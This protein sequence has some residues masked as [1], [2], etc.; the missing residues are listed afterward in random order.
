MN[1]SSLN[2][3]PLD[4]LSVTLKSDFIDLQ[5]TLSVAPFTDLQAEITVTTRPAIDLQAQISVLQSNSSD[6]LAELSIGPV[7]DVNAQIQVSNYKWASKSL[8]DAQN[9]LV[10][11]PY[12]KCFVVDDNIVPN[13]KIVNNVL[14]PMRYFKS[15]TAPDGS[16]L[17]TGND[18][19]D[20][21]GFWKITDASDS[22][23]WSASATAQVAPSTLNPIFADSEG[24][25]LIDINVSDWINGTYVIDI[26]FV[27]GNNPYYLYWYRSLDGGQ[28]WTQ[29]EEPIITLTP[30]TAYLSVASPQNQAKDGFIDGFVL[31]TDNNQLTYY[32]YLGSGS[33]MYNI[34]D[35][36]FN[37]QEWNLNGASVFYNKDKDGYF[38]VFSGYHSVFENSTN[39]GLYSFYLYPSKTSG[40]GPNYD[41]TTFPK[42]ILTSPSSSQQN[43]NSYNRP[44]LNFDGTYLWLNYQATIVTSY[45]QNTIAGST[46]QITTQNQNFLCKSEDFENFTY[47]T[48]IIFTDGTTLNGNTFRAWPYSF[49]YQNGYYYFAGTNNGSSEAYQNVWQYVQNDIIADVSNYILN[50][51]ISE[52]AGS[53]S[54]LSIDIG[55]Q[56]SQWY[57]PAPTQTGYQAIAKNN[58]IYLFQGYYNSSGVP[59]IAPRNVYYIDDITQNTTYNQ[60]S[61]TLTGRDFY[62]KLKVNSSQYT[63]N[64]NGPTFLVDPFNNSSLPNWSPVSGQWT[65]EP[66]GTGAVI[67]YLV[68][69]A[70][71]QSD[72]IIVLNGVSNI[73]PQQT[74]GVAF[75]VPDPTTTQAIYF[76]VSYQ[77]S[78]HWKRIKISGNGLPGSTTWN[79]Y[80]Q[81]NNG[82]LPET[83]TTSS[84]ITF[85]GYEPT[86][87]SGNFSYI[88]IRTNEYQAAMDV[89]VLET[90]NAASSADDVENAFNG[91]TKIFSDNTDFNFSLNTNSIGLGCLGYIAQ[92]YDFRFTQ[93]ENSNNIKQITESIGRKVNITDYVFENSFEGD[94]V[95]GTNWTSCSGAPSQ[96][97][98]TTGIQN[99]NLYLTSGQLVYNN[100]GGTNNDGVLDNLEINFS[101]YVE[102][103]TGDDQEFSVVLR[104]SSL[105]NYLSA[106]SYQ[107]VF[108]KNVATSPTNLTYVELLINT[109][110]PSGPTYT[111]YST[112]QGSIDN[113]NLSFDLSQSHDYKI[114]MNYQW[115][116]VFIDGIMVLAWYANA[117]DTANILTSGYL[118]FLVPSSLSSESLRITSFNSGIFWNQIPNYSINPNDDFETSIE[119]NLSTIQAWYFSDTGGRMKCVILNTTDP[120][121]YYYGDNAS[122]NQTLFNLPDTPQNQ[123]WSQN[124]DSSDKEYVNQ[125]IVVGNGVSATAQNNTS[126]ASTGNIRTTVITD[127]KIT[128]I[129]DAQTRANY[130]LIDLNKMNTQPSPKQI[131]NVGSELFDVVNIKD[132]LSNNSSG[133]DKNE[134]IYNQNI[135]I[136]GSKNDYS[137]TLGLGSLE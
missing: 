59:E 119:T 62:K 129:A 116:Y 16:I 14:N 61:L 26:S 94:L 30:G 123:L 2:S 87:P 57:G 52:T 49:V 31:Y 13:S 17:V 3:S 9:Q 66:I 72:S 112:Y 4:S 102:Q 53:P 128:T 115:I 18:G 64:F 40:L 73:T 58:K 84:N 23:Q 74:M 111:L 12:M 121:S 60:N 77:D 39:S 45:N 71:P 98:P 83:I 125:V 110:L 120:V 69:S 103:T 55:N 56:N 78:T 54:S 37:T 27:G 8:I 34:I 89:R 107:L 134:R 76:Y 126:I 33:Y 108:H 101:G 105:S 51:Q 48:Q 131:N 81:I 109:N 114:V 24:D 88:L 42:E 86:N 100:T 93:Y 127:Y 21:V 70:S 10:A 117:I 97:N 118:G 1:N 65:T 20:N 113:S 68:P 82:F 47:P 43:Q 44:S 106:Y 80:T 91:S 90:C 79:V 6:L 50:Y 136:D 25:W 41:T 38:I 63:Y 5:A 133:I 95:T 104:S 85:S 28:T 75:L 67:G 7:S 22:S 92:F 19:S 132:T 135:N 11:R 137:I 46:T 99:N 130:E 35:S 124:I 96:W 29:L 122:D 15:V 32:Y 36:N